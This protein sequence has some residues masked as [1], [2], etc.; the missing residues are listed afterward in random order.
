MLI[1]SKWK[2]LQRKILLKIILGIRVEIKLIKLIKIFLWQWMTTRICTYYKAPSTA[3]YWI[4]YR[5]YRVRYMSISTSMT[6]ASVLISSCEK[7]FMCGASLCIYLMWWNTR[8]FIRRRDNKFLHA[9]TSFIVRPGWLSKAQ[10][11][12]QRYESVCIFTLGSLNG[13]SC[14]KVRV[15]FYVS[16]VYRN[17]L[18]TI[19]H[20]ELNDTSVKPV[21]IIYRMA[22]HLHQIIFSKYL[23]SF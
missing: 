13:S 8:V 15:K 10:K 20:L 16:L 12:L 9:F 6:S 1:K 7:G 5:L 11:K 14:T 18:R 4:L 3:S 2:F 21:K 22:L 19:G 23:Y 17:Y